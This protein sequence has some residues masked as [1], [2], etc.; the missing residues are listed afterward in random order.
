MTNHID[1]STSVC[2]C[3]CV[4]LSLQPHSG[5]DRGPDLIR[6][7]GLLRRLQEL[8]VVTLSKYTRGSQIPFLCVYM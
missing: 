5:V 8:G 2:V 6:A 7:A 4:S 3:V 1:R